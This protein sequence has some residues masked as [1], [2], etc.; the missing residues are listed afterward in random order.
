MKI[1]V[2][3]DEPLARERLMRLLEKVKP[4]ARL[5]EAGDGKQALELIASQQPELIMLDIR[6]PGMDGIAVASALQ[7]LQEPPAVIFCTAYDQY[8]L[9]AMDHQAVAY[10]LKPVREEKLR[11]VL[12]RA[13]RLNRLQLTALKGGSPARSHLVSESRR[14]VETTEVGEV[15]CFIAEQKYVRAV[16]P[17]GSLLLSET[18]K[19][20]EEEFG[21]RFLRVHRNALVSL[22][23]IRGLNRTSDDSWFVV[24]DA[25]EEQPSVS[26]RHLSEVKE[27]LR[28]R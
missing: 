9:E 10:L 12:K 22:A 15:R 25:V 1:L 28:A 20:L 6:M 26:R 17:E 24:L 7:N 3:D 2:V 23:H 21:G 19:E 18:L 16:H 5:E 11:E 13:G 27:T 4:D 8:A 14:G